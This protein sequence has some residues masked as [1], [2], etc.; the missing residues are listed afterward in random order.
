MKKVIGGARY[1]TTTAQLLASWEMGDIVEDDLQYCEETLY[2]TKAGR[3]FLHGSGGAST[4]YA[5]MREGGGMKPG[6][7]IIPIPEDQA[8]ALVAQHCDADQYD[9]IFGAIEEGKVQRT[10]YLSP[11]ADRKLEELK[12][13]TGLSIP[14]LIDR[15]ILAYGKDVEK[16]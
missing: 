14:Q 3:Y 1:D 2:R 9:A 15:A 7:A 13:S 12:T 8:R 10:V 16:T 11:A 5:A 6:E 4:R